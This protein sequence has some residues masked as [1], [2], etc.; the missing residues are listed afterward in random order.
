MNPTRPAIPPSGSLASP[1]P[2]SPHNIGEIIGGLASDI[3]DLVRGEIALA[4]SELDQK[5]HRVI[6]AAIW[7]LGGA[8]LG[9]AGLVVLLQG[10]AAILALVLPVWASALIVG[11]VIIIVGAVFAKTGLAK[12]SLKDLSPDRTAANVQRDAH[13]LKEHV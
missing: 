2:D 7:L 10:I 11:G 8:L 13:M 4:R 6:L 5:L 3:Q 9:F 1:P 12:L